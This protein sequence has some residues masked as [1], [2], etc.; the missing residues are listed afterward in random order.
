ML[1]VYFLS[2]LPNVVWSRS[3]AKWDDIGAVGGAN[4]KYDFVTRHVTV[5]IG[6]FLLS[7]HIIVV[8]LYSASL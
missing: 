2:S 5:E 6:A 3:L 8:N 7:R 1:C 4:M